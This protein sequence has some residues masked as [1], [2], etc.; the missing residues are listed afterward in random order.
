MKGDAELCVER[1]CELAPQ[2]PASEMKQAA[3]PCMDD[4]QLQ[5]EDVQ[6]V[7]EHASVCA[8]IVSPFTRIGRPGI[9]WTVDTLARAVTK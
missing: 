2:K 9:S 8:E 1:Y 5:T 7:G 4:H 6:V 3:T